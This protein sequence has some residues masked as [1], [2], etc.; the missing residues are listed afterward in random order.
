VKRRYT[1]GRASSLPTPHTFACSPAATG[2]SWRN[3]RVDKLL[4]LSKPEGLPYLKGLR[5]GAVVRSIPDLLGALGLA[6]W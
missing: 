6:K 2:I 5:Y 4:F 1:R 3:G